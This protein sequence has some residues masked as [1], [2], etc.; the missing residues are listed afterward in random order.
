MISDALLQRLLRPTLHATALGAALA[1]A[2][3]LAALLRLLPEPGSAVPWIVLMQVLLAPG[4]ILAT[5]W[6]YRAG[7]RTSQGFVWVALRLAR[8]GATVPWAWL[9]LA[10]MLN[11][12]ATL[13]VLGPAQVVEMVENLP[14]FDRAKAALLAS[15][16]LLT[17]VC[18]LL[19]LRG[20]QDEALPDP[21]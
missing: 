1:L 17:E 14:H 10:A 5:L 13:A 18:L 15:Q 6:V 19:V 3:N 20:A 16:W 4:M 7:C 12:L 2:L 21:A 8:R 11:V 9:L